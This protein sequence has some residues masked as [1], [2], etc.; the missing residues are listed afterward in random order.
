MWSDRLRAKWFWYNWE[1][2]YV[3][4]AEILKGVRRCL[5]FGKHCSKM[6]GYTIWTVLQSPGRL[7][8]SAHWWAQA[9][10][11]TGLYRVSQ[12]YVYT[13]LIFHKKNEYTFFWDI[14][15]TSDT[16][17]T[18]ILKQYCIKQLLVTTQWHVKV[19]EVQ[20]GIENVSFTEEPAVNCYVTLIPTVLL[21]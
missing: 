16:L 2:G 20:N 3:D 1:R 19:V 13:R 21:D 11:Q 12:K 8:Y 7:Y 14:L 5:K 18:S 10:K 9:N 4:K 15:Y 6:S 17:H